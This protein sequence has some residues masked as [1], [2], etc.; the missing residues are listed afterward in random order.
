MRISFI[1]HQITAVIEILA[2][3]LAVHWIY[4]NWASDRYG[5]ITL[6]FLIAILCGVHGLLHLWE[7]SFYN[8]NPFFGSST[9]RDQPVPIPVRVVQDQDR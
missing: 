3:L 9:V 1:Y 7:E 5:G 2:T 6:L 4:Q 8:F